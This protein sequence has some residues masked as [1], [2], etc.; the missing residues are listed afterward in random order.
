MVTTS[1][2]PVPA[3]TLVSLSCNEG[4]QLKGDHEVTCTHNVQFLFTENPTC[5]K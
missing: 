1:T 5:G 2:F 3:G 4:Y